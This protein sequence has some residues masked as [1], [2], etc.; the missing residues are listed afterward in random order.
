MKPSKF[1]LLMIIFVILPMC[2][3]QLAGGAEP[4]EFDQNN[5]GDVDGRDLYLY[6]Q[7]INEAP[8]DHSDL[9]LQFSKSDCFIVPAPQITF[10]ASP[11]ITNGTT[12]ATLS[13][14]AAYADS[15]SIAPDP[16]D[17]TG[18]SSIV[19]TPAATTEYTLTATGK[20]GASQRKITGKLRDVL[21]F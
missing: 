9:A 11:E 14:T 12:A 2:S 19:V 15:I 5:D 3:V 8:A 10:A 17:V 6:A 18:S 4:C 1:C 7:S 21:K 13:W 16:G 20:G